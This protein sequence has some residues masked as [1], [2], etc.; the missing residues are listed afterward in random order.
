MADL[1]HKETDE[2]LERLE[3]RIKK[4]YK[5]ASKEIEAKTKAFMEQF[6]KAD[7]YKRSL[8]K[9]GKIT[10]AQY[11]KWRLSEIAMGNRW[12]GMKETLTEDWH[13]ADKI[14]RK[15]V[16]DERIDVYALNHNYAAYEIEHDTEMDTSF[17]LYNHE[18]V[19]RLLKDDPKVLP[20]P[21][22][23][24]ARKIAEGKAKRWS[25][26]KLQSIMIQSILQGES[27]P[28]IAKR[29]TQEM[30]EMSANAAIRN[31]RTMTTAAEAAG[32]I[33]AYKQAEGMGINMKQMW[34]AT[35]DGRTRHA[36][37]MLDG[38]RVEVG[39]PFKVDGYEIRFPGDPTA[40][41]YLIYNCRCTVAGVVKGSELDKKGLEG[42][43]RNSK[44]GNMS[45]KEWKKSKIQKKG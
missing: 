31:A 7:E 11:K 26:K 17:T 41:G 15:M 8:V 22:K 36:H 44:L 39:K 27:I 21:G 9:A 28:N 10:E 33:D 3:K 6:K 25:N 30:G 5:Q 14:A 23:G 32:R 38:Q 1:G 20:D 42:M 24:T 43:K 16:N 29:L 35:L 37:R 18:S 19:E 12:Q 34:V 2:L 4:E 45:Y 13:N 40:P